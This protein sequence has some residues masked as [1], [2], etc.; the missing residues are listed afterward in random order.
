MFW[1]IVII[2]VLVIVAVGI[3]GATFPANGGPSGS[4]CDRCK[5]LPPYWRSLSLIKKA[6]M[7]PYIFWL[8]IDCKLRNC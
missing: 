4:G 2:V 5:Q 3:G 8:L 6:W 1:T 7:S